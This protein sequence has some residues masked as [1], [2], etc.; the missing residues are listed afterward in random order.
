MSS[1]SCK[2]CSGKGGFNAIRADKATVD[3]S[4]G[5]IL[6]AGKTWKVFIPCRQCKGTGKEQAS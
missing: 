3:V 1:S 5:K 2:T 6:K 4:T